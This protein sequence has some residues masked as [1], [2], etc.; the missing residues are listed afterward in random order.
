MKYET[1][2]FR[3]YQ[4]NKQNANEKENKMVWCYDCG[5]FGEPVQCEEG[6]G[7]Y[8]PDGTE[9]TWVRDCCPH[10]GSAEVEEADV[11]ELCGNEIVP[12]EGRSYCED[13][14][15]FAFKALE[16]AFAEYEKAYGIDKMRKIQDCMYEAFEKWLEEKQLWIYEKEKLK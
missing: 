12:H 1:V 8:A 10:C 2:S 4:T 9:E 5:R 16:N 7:V 15:E 6:T 13:C 3:L 14:Y 11:C